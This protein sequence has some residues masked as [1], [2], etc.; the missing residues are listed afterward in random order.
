MAKNTGDSD[1]GGRN[2]IRYLVLGGI[3]LFGLYLGAMVV[4]VTL[5]AGGYGT[6]VYDHPVDMNWSYDNASNTVVLTHTGGPSLEAS[7]T[8]VHRNL[9]PH[10]FESNAT[11]GPGDTIRVHNVTRDD[12]IDVYRGSTEDVGNTIV[13]FTVPE[14]TATE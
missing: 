11:I 3:G 14:S 4:A 10:P 1:D 9:D 7:N 13:S 8:T 2:I 6:T 5:F 12:H